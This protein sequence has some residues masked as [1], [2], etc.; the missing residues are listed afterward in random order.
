M[1]SLRVPSP[2]SFDL[3]RFQVGDFERRLRLSRDCFLSFSP[4]FEENNFRGVRFGVRS[5]KSEVAFTAAE[6]EETLPEEL[7]PELMPKHVAIIMDGN[8]R[9]AKNR[10][11]QPWDGH[12]AGVEA[13][14]EIVKLSGKWGIQVLT[15]FAFSTDNWI[16]PR[17]SKNL[18]FNL[19][20]T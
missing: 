12:R 10:G 15:V 13:L 9:W 1:L 3:R 20:I 16:R 14:K 17:V 19:D 4:K 11:L 6:E 2:T 5:S 18:I 7:Q 8:G